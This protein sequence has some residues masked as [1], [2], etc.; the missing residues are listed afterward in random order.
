MKHKHQ[1]IRTHSS[2]AVDGRGWQNHGWVQCV[3]PHACAADPRRQEA[4]GGVTR[5]DVCRCGATRRSE[6]NGGRVNYGPWEEK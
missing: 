1:A 6:R 3:T 2:D 4:H 5:Y